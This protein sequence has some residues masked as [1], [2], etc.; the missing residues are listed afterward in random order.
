MSGL[1]KEIS[2]KLKDYISG[3]T[4]VC[5]ILGL[6]YGV[7]FYLLD[8]YMGFVIGMLLGFMTFVP[9]IGPMIGFLFCLAISIID[10]QGWTNLGVL[11]G[12]FIF[13]QIL[14]G[15]FLTPKIVGNKT[16]LHPLA[17]FMCVM[18][19]GMFFG[20]MGMVF[21]V[22][23]AITAVVIIKY[24]GLYKVDTKPIESKTEE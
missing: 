17:V 1:A 23:L 7:S 3:Q 22:P 19:G 5:L 13:G 8:I 15:N 24:F 21:A 12:V 10:F 14:E 20:I 4:Q 9:I 6:L 18:A 16:G 11:F 2:H